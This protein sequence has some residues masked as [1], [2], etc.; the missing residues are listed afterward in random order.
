MVKIKSRIQL[1]NFHAKESEYKVD[2]IVV[3]LKS[4]GNGRNIM[5]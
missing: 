2:I 1:D 5:S 4:R 3:S